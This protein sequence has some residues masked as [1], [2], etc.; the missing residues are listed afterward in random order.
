[1]S[2]F[3]SGVVGAAALVSAFGMTQFAVGKSLV[4][5]TQDLAVAQSGMVNRAMKT[6]RDADVRPE[7]GKTFV[8]RISALSDTSVAIRIPK[9]GGN[10]ESVV[11]SRKP[12]K[13]PVACEASAS[14]LTEV[15]KL[16]ESARCVT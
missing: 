3:V 8:T 15:A 6:D 5:K 9:T 12:S 1:M 14:V 10:Q 7:G 11:N 4:G 2:K 13:R 16:M